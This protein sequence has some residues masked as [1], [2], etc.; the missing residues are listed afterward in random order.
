MNPNRSASAANSVPLKNTGPEPVQK[1]TATTIAGFGA[2]LFGTYSNIRRF[3]GLGPKFVTSVSA[4]A[5]A[6][7]DVPRTAVATAASTTMTAAMNAAGA[8]R[9]PAR[10]RGGGSDRDSG[11]RRR[12]TVRIMAVSLCASRE[13]ATGGSEIFQQ[14][15]R[16]IAK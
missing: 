8:A 9:R 3:V 10:D 14:S 1:C 13:H 16:I 7:R 4:A 5:D 12:E 2:T 11:D 6:G 15:F